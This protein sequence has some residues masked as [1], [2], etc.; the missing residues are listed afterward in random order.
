MLALDRHPFSREGANRP[1]R[2]RAKI[3]CNRS[4]TN[5]T[6]SYLAYGLG[7]RA[8]IPLPELVTGE[9]EE[10]VSIHFGRVEHPR[11]MET[12]DAGSKFYSPNPEEDHLFWGGEGSRSRSVPG[13]RRA[14]TTSPIAGA[15]PGSAATSARAPAATRQ[16]SGRGRR[17]YPFFGKLGSRKIY[18]GC[19]VTRPGAWL[20]NRRCGGTSGRGEPPHGV[21]WVSPTKAVAGSA[22]LLGRRSGEAAP[23]EPVPRKTRPY[24]R[25]RILTDPSTRQE[26]LYTRRRQCFGDLA[27]QAPRS[28]PR[29]GAPHLRL[30]LR[31][32]ACFGGRQRFS[33]LQV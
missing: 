6:F 25:N 19:G 11:F 9:A 10:A 16:R 8:A 1:E 23:V 27:S 32:A 21:P 29:T 13:T 7:I 26:D 18:H 12:A 3:C 31:F 28:F 2:W 30:R 33:L 4:T 15:G 20:G 24:G 14:G 17:G 5:S 22:R